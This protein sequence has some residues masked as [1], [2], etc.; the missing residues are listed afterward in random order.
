MDSKEPIGLQSTGS[1]R[2]G[3][4]RVTNTLTSTGSPKPLC[5]KPEDPKTWCG[6][7]TQGHSSQQPHLSPSRHPHQ[8]TKIHE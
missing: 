2:V 5:E 3:H 4:D 6:V 7:V 1:Q 8:S